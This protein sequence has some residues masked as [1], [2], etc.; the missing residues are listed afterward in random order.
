MLRDVVLYSLFIIHLFGNDI[1][2]FLSVNHFWRF[3]SCTFYLL[4]SRYPNTGLVANFCRIGGWTQGYKPWCY[5]MDEDKDWEYCNI[6]IC[7]DMS[8]YGPTG[9]LQNNSKRKNRYFPHQ[10]IKSYL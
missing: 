3:P 4:T 9:K 6:P 2:Y 8:E 1:C 7:L 5:T 10:S